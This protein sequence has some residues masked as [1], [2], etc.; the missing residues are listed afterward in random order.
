MVVAGKEL[1]PKAPTI[2]R[3]ATYAPW[4]LSFF[5]RK[6]QRFGTREIGQVGMRM[7]DEVFPPAIRLTKRPISGVTGIGNSSSTLGS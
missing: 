6:I 1:P 3:T 2:V 4:L 5:T 7:T